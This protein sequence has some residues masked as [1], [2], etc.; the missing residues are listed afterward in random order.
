VGEIARAHALIANGHVVP[1][2]E[3]TAQVLSSSDPS[4]WYEVNGSCSCPDNV[5]RKQQCK[6]ISAWKLYQFVERQIAAQ[7]AAAVAEMVAPSPAP[8]AVP[9]QYMTTIQGHPFVKFEGLLAMAHE[10]GLAELTTT[11]VQVSAELAVCQAVARFKD[12]RVF[13]DIGDATPHRLMLP[14]ISRPTS[15]AWRLHGPQHGPCAGP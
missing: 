9:P 15:F 4:I 3:G 1:T 6:H 14:D 2:G 5:H 13:T 8:L 12:G 11:I 10:H 7:P